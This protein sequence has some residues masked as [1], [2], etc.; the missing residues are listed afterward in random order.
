[1]D[2]EGEEMSA[3][4][5]ES[6]VAEA[7]GHGVDDDQDGDGDDMDIDDQ[8]PGADDG[9]PK[10]HEPPGED[11]SPDDTDMVVT[12][13]QVEVKDPRL[14]LRVDGDGD[15]EPGWGISQGDDLM[16]VKQG[17]LVS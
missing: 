10:H 5:L 12:P 1:L 16:V 4:A 6:M 15:G 9:D 2:G 14:R 7:I 3:E 13:I 8:E 11:N 17:A